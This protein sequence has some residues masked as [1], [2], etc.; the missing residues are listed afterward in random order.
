MPQGQALRQGGVG[1]VP[2]RT[3]IRKLGDGHSDTLG[4]CDV[5]VVILNSA[6]DRDLHVPQG[7]GL[8]VADDAVSL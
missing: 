1:E 5:L 3:R 2:P 8:L 4:T 7:R 6:Q